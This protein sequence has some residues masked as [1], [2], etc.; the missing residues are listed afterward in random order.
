MA[1]I[2]DTAELTPETQAKLNKSHTL[3]VYNG[4]DVCVTLE[5]L[6]VLLDQL[7][8]TARATYEFSLALQAPVMEM[9]NRGLLVDQVSR[10]KALA[11]YRKDID[12]LS[13]Q[14]N[15]LITEGLGIECNWRSQMQLKHLFYDVLG[16]P[17]IKKRNAKGRFMPTVDR[18]ALERLCNYRLAEPFARHLLLLRDMD[19]IR[20]SLENDIDSDGRMRTQL[21]IAGTNTGRFSS[22]ESIFGTGGNLQNIDRR[23]REVFVA[24]PGMVFI[25]LD[26]EQADSRNVGALCWNLFYDSHGPEFAGAYLDACESGDLHT[27]VCHMAWTNLEWPEDVK[28]WRAVADGVA[29]REYTYRDL[30]KRLGHGSNFRGKPRTMAKH[31]KLPTRLVEDFQYRYFKAFPCIPKWHEYITKEIASTASLTTLFG[32]RRFFW[33]RHNDDATLREAT[34]Y[35]PQSMTADE[36]NKG[37]MNIWR[38]GR[39]QLLLQVHDS[40]LIQCPVERMPETVEWALEALKVPLE[41]KGGRKFV[42]PTEAKV[43]FNYG[44]YSENNVDGLK[45]WKGSDDRVRKNQPNTKLTIRGM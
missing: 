27:Q 35:A 37:I 13:S 24:D 11:S 14:L 25:N 42:V 31:T 33:G 9:N 41:L 29:Y 10:Q 4:L 44:D 20:S 17:P 7:D 40:I 36:I 23:L 22:A 43:G 26:L 1:T 28:G 39:T 3:Q 5:I 45:K 32:R 12:R 38:D 21:N 16:I 8:D 30:A 19:K 34:A 18:D 2:I 6:H 15:T